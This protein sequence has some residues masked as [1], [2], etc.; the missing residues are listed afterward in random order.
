MKREQT[1]GGLSCGQVL[2]GLS[3][4]LDGEMPAAQRDQV[5]AHVRGCAL[6]AR[7]GGVFAATV[8]GLRERLGAAEDVPTDVARRLDES[9]RLH[10]REGG[11]A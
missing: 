1:V 9:L 6:C 10:G 4:Y 11:P 8:R 2:A 5:E 7:F 3:D